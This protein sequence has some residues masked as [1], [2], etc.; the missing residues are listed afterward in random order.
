MTVSSSE[1]KAAVRLA[2]VQY[3]LT[4]PNATKACAET[5]MSYATTDNCSG[6]QKAIGHGPVVELLNVAA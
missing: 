4:T 6:S 2:V 1:T 5:L 3:S